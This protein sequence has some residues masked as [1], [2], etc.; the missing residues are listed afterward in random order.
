[1]PYV[2]TT[3]CL[4]H[5]LLNNK[6]DDGFGVKSPFGLQCE[7]DINGALSMQILKNITNEFPSYRYLYMIMKN[8][9]HFFNCGSQQ[10]ILPV[11]K[12][13]LLGA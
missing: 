6:T 8:T 5:S 12:G 4:A 3:F 9:W 11:K 7:A 2:Y 13:C 1:M 10:Q